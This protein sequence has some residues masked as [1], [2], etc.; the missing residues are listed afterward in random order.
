MLKFDTKNHKFESLPRSGL[1]SEAILER[2]DLQKAM[3][4]SWE[5]FK[6]E[7]GLPT[8]FL[9]GQEVNPHSSTQDAI[10][11]LAYNPDESSL[12]VIELKRD[13]HKLQLL[14]ALSYAAM[15][16]HWDTDELITKIQRD[17][18][19]DPQ[20]LVD[21]VSVG[22]LS[23]DVKVLL[24]AESYD[25]EVIL[26]ADWLNGYYSVD[27][28]ALAVSLHLVGEET[29]LTFEQRFPLKELSDAY[30]DRGKR[31]AKKQK[32][33]DIE[34]ED[35]LPKL[36]Y[37]FAGRGI[38][39]CQ[40]IREG[41]PARRRFGRI[42]TNFQG[43]N[44]ISLNFREKYINVYIKGNFEGDQD[45]LKS[46]FRHEITIGTWRDGL[47]FLVNNENQ[48]EDLVKWLQLE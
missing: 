31:R 36:K 8:S 12:T 33:I 29:F 45:Y 15:V 18:N 27:I 32:R 23:S 22:E 10:D 43:F 14:Q 42:R 30:E 48:F 2:Y 39:L 3:V 26:T 44:W 4:Q 41:D 21:L 17:I 11:L 9:I 35:V 37:P 6:N 40:R 25:P 46:K 16:S 28:T 34:W 5:V 38:E 20:E 13:R 19:P 1:K 7:I 47:S 24:I